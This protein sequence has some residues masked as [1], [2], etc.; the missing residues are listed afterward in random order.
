MRNGLFVLSVF[1]LFVGVCYILTAHP[2]FIGS[3]SVLTISVVLCY[4]SWM[5][6]HRS[7]YK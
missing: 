3:A 4:A 1:T 6:E 2:P 7:W 5:K